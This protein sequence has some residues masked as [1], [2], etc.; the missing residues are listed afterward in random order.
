MSARTSGGSSQHRLV[1][2]GLNE[3]FYGQYN[4]TMAYSDMKMRFL[5]E[6]YHEGSAS[7][8]NMI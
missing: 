3:K 8:Q 4:A 5:G 1:G 6:Q 7:V 2:Q